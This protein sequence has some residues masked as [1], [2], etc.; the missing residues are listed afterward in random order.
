MF[1]MRK[2]IDIVDALVQKPEMTTLLEKAPDGKHDDSVDFR[3]WF[4]DSAVV[5]GAGAPLKLYFHRA[6]STEHGKAI[7][8]ATQPTPTSTHHAICIYAP[9]RSAKCRASPRGARYYHW[10]KT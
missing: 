7:L 9:S 6:V 3:T 5:D 8:F 2:S 4:D 10:R 1:D